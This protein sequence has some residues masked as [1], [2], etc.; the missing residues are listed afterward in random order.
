MMN[1]IALFLIDDHPV[2]ISGVKT[3]LRDQDISVTGSAQS[4]DE[5][6]N[7]A[8]DNEF[9]V[10]LLDLYIPGTHPVDNIKK[11]RERFPIAPIVVFTSE[12]DEPWHRQMMGLGISGYVVKNAPKEEL[13]FVL[14]KAASGEI[15]SISK[16]HDKLTDLDQS[17]KVLT[18]NQMEILR[19]IAKGKSQEEI[20]KIKCTT[21]S[22][23]E[24]TMQNIR[25]K[26]NCNTTIQ[27][28]KYCS[29]HGYLR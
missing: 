14:K 1:T 20:S 2:S 7:K 17:E 6:L 5:F 28:I 10:I 21:V 19:M 9:Q 18:N 22:N 29:E 13:I 26:L 12:E 4:I 8:N 24:K 3:M 23:I 25:R 16:Q 15:C 11:I 27:V